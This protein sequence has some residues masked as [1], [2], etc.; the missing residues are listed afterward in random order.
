VE[1]VANRKKQKQRQKQLQPKK[2]SL[3]QSGSAFRRAIYSQG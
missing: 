2:Y 3:R 1:E